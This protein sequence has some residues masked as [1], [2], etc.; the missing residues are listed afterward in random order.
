MAVARS[1]M[2]A[3]DVFMQILQLLFDSFDY[4]RHMS[5]LTVIR[6]ASSA[7][8]QIPSGYNE[9]IFTSRRRTEGIASW[10]ETTIHGELAGRQ[11]STPTPRS[12]CSPHTPPDI[13]DRES[14]IHSTSS[15]ST[16]PF[17]A[18]VALRPSSRQISRW[19][20]LQTVRVP[21]T[22]MVM[23]ISCSQRLALCNPGMKMSQQVAHKN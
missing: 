6:A 19:N 1:E 5:C 17:L 4:K 18:K 14:E 3:A 21:P 22:D 9:W 16:S 12:K 7:R 11:H 15:T 2:M 20:P 8:F 13:I 10:Q 23:K